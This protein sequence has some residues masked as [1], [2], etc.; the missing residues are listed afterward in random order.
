MIANNF[1]AMERVEQWVDEGRPID[2]DA[3]LAL[4]RTVTDGTLSARDVGCLQTPDDA[5]VY[6]VSSSGGVVHQPP[7][8]AELP[9]RMERLCAFASDES[10]DP[11]IHP[12]VRAVLLHFM[13]G[14]DHPFADGN[15]RTARALFYWSLMRSGFWLAPYLSISQFLLEAPAQYSRAYQYVTADANDVTHFLLHQLEILLRAADRLRQYLR[16]EQAR[17]LALDRA[18]VGLNDRQAAVIREALSDPHQRFTIA[19]QRRE[20]RISYAVARSDLLDLEARA[21]LTKVRTGKKFVFRPA[22]DLAERLSTE[23]ES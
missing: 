15:G 5:R 4:H 22:P 20:H 18:A 7:P 16:S 10:D 1:A 14:Y 2:L 11:L 12:A 21:L 13:I 17:S 19:R 8:A 6:V 3:I 23:S 9:E